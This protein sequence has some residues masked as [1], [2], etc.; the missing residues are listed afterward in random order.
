MNASISA[1]D[2]VGGD[3]GIPKSVGDAVNTHFACAKSGSHAVSG[4]FKRRKPAP[5]L[6][7]LKS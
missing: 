7:N 5:T 6:Q 3:F 4:L 2:A 1:F